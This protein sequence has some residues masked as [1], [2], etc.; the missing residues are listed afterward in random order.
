[1][2][3]QKVLIVGG[4]IAGLTA[5]T[6]LRRAGFEIDI[7]ELHPR[8]LGEGV[9]IFQMSNALRALAT[10]GLAEPCVAA[11]HPISSLRFY[12]G[13]GQFRLEVPQ[14]ALA[15]PKYPPANGITRP[16][17]H[18]ILQEAVLACGATVRLGLTVST[19][20]QEDEAVA[21]TFSDDTF[22]R[23]DL[24]IGAD[25]LRS[26]IRRLVFGSQHQP[27]YVGQVVWRCNVPRLPEVETAWFFEGVKGGRVGFI[28]DAPDL[29]YILL[30]EAPP[31]GPP[32]WIAEDRLVSGLG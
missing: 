10:L 13:Q 30:I 3:V 25:G 18:A 24:V 17:L 32:P 22:A 19:L 6:A 14:P 2:S 28:P 5:A 26:V 12:D 21:V 16:R 11:G 1:M 31:P 27:R 23:Y 8:W 7:V 29:M 4:G 15:G 20:V 9:G